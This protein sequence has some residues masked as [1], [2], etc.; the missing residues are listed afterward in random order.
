MAVLGRL[1]SRPQ[2]GRL[3]GRGRGG[4]AF[5]VHLSLTPLLW[6]SSWLQTVPG[7]LVGGAWYPRFIDRAVRPCHTIE[8][9]GCENLLVP[10]V[11][12]SAPSPSG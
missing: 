7:S 5:L 8:D 10:E 3:A 4:R 1:I 6:L 12:V 9:A 2:G 11:D